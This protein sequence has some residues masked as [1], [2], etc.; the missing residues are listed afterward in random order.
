MAGLPLL[1]LLS[2]ATNHKNQIVSFL[3]LENEFY[4]TPKALHVLD[5]I[6]ENTEPL[7]LDKGSDQAQVHDMLQTVRAEMLKTM[8]G[9]YNKHVTLLAESLETGQWR[10]DKLSFLFYAIGQKNHWPIDIVL[11]P[12]HA[13]IRW[14]FKDNSFLNWETTNAKAY[15]NDHYLTEFNISQKAI[16]NGIYMTPLTERQLQA[17]VCNNIGRAWFEKEQYEKALLYCSKAIELWPRFSEAYNNRAIV[18]IYL[19]DTDQALQDLN[20]TVELDPNCAAAHYNR[21]RIFFDSSELEKALRDFRTANELNPR[22]MLVLGFI[23]YI[24]SIHEKSG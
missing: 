10:C 9:G 13:F 1:F 24:E 17:V 12:N 5:Y 11:A 14:S 6:L 21:G 8:D 16:R 23:H 22:N 15:T 20:R 7:G 4:Q 2:C 19:K 18:E 3:E